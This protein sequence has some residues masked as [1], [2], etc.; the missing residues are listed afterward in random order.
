M[1]RNLEGRSEILKM[2]TLRISALLCVRTLSLLL[3]LML[4]QFATGATEEY[5]L[6]AG[7]EIAISVYREED[8]S[9]SLQIDES[10][11]FNYPYLGKIQAIGRTLTELE[12]TLTEGLLQDILVNPSVNVSIVRYRNFYIG[13]EVKAP[14]GYAYNPGLTIQQAITVAGGP[15]EWASKSKFQIVREGQ[16]NPVAANNSTVVR[17]GDTVTVLEGIF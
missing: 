13:G 7:D 14:G 17:P 9:M 6:G 8:L 1:D 2:M 4:P 10:G 12:Q 16:A 11:M 3:V 15:T 5:R